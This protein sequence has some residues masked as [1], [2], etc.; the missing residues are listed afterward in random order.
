[1]NAG[2][3][4]PTAGQPDAIELPQVFSIHAFACHQS[5]PAGHPRGSCGAAGAGPLWERLGAKLESARL[6]GV[7]MTATGCL[8]FC[9]AGPLMVVYPQGVWYTPRTTED[10]DAIVDEHFVGGRIVE[11][12]AIVPRL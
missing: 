4:S 12:L 3:P 5:R 2:S 8:G 11:R 7:A 6:P 9:P 1:M 10:I